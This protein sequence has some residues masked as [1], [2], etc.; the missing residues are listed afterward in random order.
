MQKVRDWNAVIAWR[1][2]ARSSQPKKGKGSYN[3]AKV[4]ANMR[5]G[6]Y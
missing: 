2:S 6:N 4:V 1:L 5:K 3:R